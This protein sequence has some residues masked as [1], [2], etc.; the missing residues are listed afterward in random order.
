MSI[1]KLLYNIW[2]SLVS[3]LAALGGGSSGV[4]ITKV[5]GAANLATTQVTLVANTSAT[6]AAARATRRFVRIINTS[7][8][9]SVLVSETNPATANNSFAIPAESSEDVPFLGAIYA[10]STGTPVLNMQDFYD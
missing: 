9:S 6:L 8:T 5:V 7:T 3:I 4:T 10:I 2:Q 1:G